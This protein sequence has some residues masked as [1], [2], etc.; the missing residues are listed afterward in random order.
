MLN[1]TNM[2]QGEITALLLRANYGHLGCSRDDHPYV[3]PMNFAYDAR[4]IYFLTT[5][6]TKTEFISANSEVCLQ[7]EEVTDSHHWRSAMVMGRAERVTKPEEVEH[8]MQLLTERNPTLTPAINKTEVGAWK[9]PG[10]F[11][12]YRIRP[13]ALYG[14]KTS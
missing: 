13:A 8:A 11:V 1:V 12:V 7:V 2:A 4:D 5:E 9:R 14:R 10:S 6:G 3:V